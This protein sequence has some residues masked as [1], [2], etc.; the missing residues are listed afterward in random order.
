MKGIL[1]NKCDDVKGFS[2]IVLA[3]QDETISVKMLKNWLFIQVLVKD[4]NFK[5]NDSKDMSRTLMSTPSDGLS[6]LLLEKSQFPAE[7]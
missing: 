1:T 3:I 7:L 5:H 2:T 6:H 4:G